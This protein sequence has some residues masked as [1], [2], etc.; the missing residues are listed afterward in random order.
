[1]K[2]D[3]DQPLPLLFVVKNSSSVLSPSRFEL[4]YQRHSL[5]RSET[6]PLSWKT[7]AYSLCPAV[8]LLIVS[9]TIFLS[10]RTFLVRGILMRSINAGFPYDYRTRYGGGVFL[11]SRP[12]C[13]LLYWCLYSLRL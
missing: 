7:R 11:P 12:L 13:L 8:M 6:N 10:G 4:F 1:M 9:I 3:R 5:P 2:T